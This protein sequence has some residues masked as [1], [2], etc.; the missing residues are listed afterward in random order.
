MQVLGVFL[1][2][3]QIAFPGAEAEISI[4]SEA[5]TVKFACIQR[6]TLSYIPHFNG[7]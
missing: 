3:Q 4:F 6:K 5:A 2:K 1:V 7:Y